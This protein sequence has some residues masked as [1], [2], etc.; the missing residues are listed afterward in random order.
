MNTGNN[1]VTRQSGSTPTGTTGP[2]GDHTSG[3]GSYVYIETSGNY[4]QNFQIEAPLLTGAGTVTFWYHMFGPG[5]GDLSVLV[6]FD[7]NWNEI[8]SI[9]HD[10][11][12]KWL[13][14]EV[15]VGE[16]G[17]T[18]IRFSF[19]SGGDSY[20]DIAIDDVTV[21]A[22]EE[23]NPTTSP[24]PTLSMKPSLSP[25]LSSSPVP[26]SAALTTAAQLKAALTSSSSSY[27][28]EI[29]LGSDIFLSE[30]L[31]IYGGLYS[32]DGNGHTINGQ[33]QVRCLN[34]SNGAQVDL[35]NVTFT[36]CLGFEVGGA[37]LMSSDAAMTITDSVFKDNN[38]SGY[39]GG[40]S[41]QAGG[42]GICCWA[43][44][45]LHVSRCSFVDNSCDGGTHLQHTGGAITAAHM[46]S[47]KAVNCTFS[48]NRARY[49]GAIRL[50][51][52]GA[53]AI[54]RTAFVNNS[55]DGFG[56]AISAVY[57]ESFDA[58]NCTFSNNRAHYGGAFDL[59][60]GGAAAITRTAFVNNSADASGGA[61]NAIIMESFDADSCTFS[62]NRAYYGGAFD[63]Y[64]G[65]AAITRTTFVKNSADQS[66]GAIYVS[67]MESFDAN[68]CTFSHNRAAYAGAIY[69]SRMVSIILNSTFLSNSARFQGG[70]IGLS[71]SIVDINNSRFISNLASGGGGG[72]IHAANSVEISMSFCTVSFNLA[73]ASSG[74]G[75]YV[76]DSNLNVKDLSSVITRRSATLS[77]RLSRETAPWLETASTVQI[78]RQT[79]AKRIVS[80]WPWLLPNWTWWNL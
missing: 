63:L 13:M 66:G 54:A 45:F 68:S 20:G 69:Q 56:G 38:V 18:A 23:L 59:Y 24:S 21:T 42:G 15:D 47:F 2:T 50:Y 16:R 26:T 12:D 53:A 57:M 39:R 62:N 3:S 73:T 79:T 65:A 25:S 49:G 34:V 9:S 80:S 14:A 74:G 75:L 30:T 37:I 78:T 17:A 28:L 29:H 11:G 22:F 35:N 64:G 8:W 19:T 70:A 31:H 76:S 5:C 41:S 60:A 36:R 61:I 71:T 52:G 7:N 48:N 72:A 55:C 46:E 51:A 4:F 10:Q 67:D 58:V 44:K 43:C 32:I 33:A 1:S 40:N 6:N 27:Q 77:S